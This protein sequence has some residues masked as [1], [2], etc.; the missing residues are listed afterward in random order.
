MDRLERNPQSWSL[1]GRT[2]LDNSGNF[3]L[4][5]GASGYGHFHSWRTE[6]GDVSNCGL[7]EASTAG[8][9]GSINNSQ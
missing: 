1:N 9:L 7:D 3:Y 2:R 8:W 4:L 6:V 5:F